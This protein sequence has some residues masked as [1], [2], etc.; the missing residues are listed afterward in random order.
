MIAGQQRAHQ[1][2]AGERAADSRQPAHGAWD[3]AHRLN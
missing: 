2:L 3:A 1:G